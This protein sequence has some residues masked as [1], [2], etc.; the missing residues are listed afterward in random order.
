MEPSVYL[1][2]VKA[3]LKLASDYQLAKVL[4]VGN[5]RIVSMRDGSRP[6]PNDVA[7]RIAKALNLDP[8]HVI[9]DLEEQREKNEKRRAFWQSVLSRAA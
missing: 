5:G 1:D 8:A 7:F 6:V 9:A 4:E 2:A 3:Q